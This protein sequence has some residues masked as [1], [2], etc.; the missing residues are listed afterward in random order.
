MG[1]YCSVF[2]KNIAVDVLMFSIKIIKMTSSDKYLM[3]PKL[4]DHAYKYLAS[5]NFISNTLRFTLIL[6]DSDELN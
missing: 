3:F 6:C 1:Q 4:M 2:T 5:S